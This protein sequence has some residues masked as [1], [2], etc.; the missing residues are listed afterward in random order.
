MVAA[1]IIV[2]ATSAGSSGPHPRSAGSRHAI[3]RSLPPYWM[4]RPG[5]TYAQISDKTGLTIDQLEAFNPNTDQFSLAP[6]QRLNLCEH[7]PAYAPTS[8]I[9]S[10]GVKRSSMP[11]C[12]RRSARITRVAS[13]IAATAAL[14]SAPR[15]VPAA[16]RTMPSSTT[17]SIAAGRRHGVEVRAEKERLSRGGRLDPGVEV[18]HRRADL[19]PA[20]VLVDLEAA[21]PQIPDHEIRDGTLLAGR[22]RQ[23]GELREQ[24][25]DV[26]RHRVSILC[27]RPIGPGC[28][29]SSY[30]L[31][32][33]AR[34]AE[35]CVMQMT[36]VSEPL[37]QASLLGEAVEHGP[38][39]VFVADENGRYVA[40]NQAACALVGYSRE[41]LLSMRVADVADDA[42][43]WEEMR[44]TGHVTGYQHPRLQGRLADRVQVHRRRDDRRRHAGLRLGRYGLSDFDAGA[45]ARAL[46][47]GV[48]ELA[49][50]RR[51]PRGP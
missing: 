27:D 6:G 19:R 44:Q 10:I 33:P 1:I 38:A 31:R 3:I 50:Q 9:S 2:V 5:D 37:I 32:K 26:R 18:A 4:V 49:E 48:D 22:A 11:A 34:T 36:G 46:E 39:A 13:S 45:R 8:P 21:V 16:F 12:G 30:L 35:V 47:R 20:A 51:R 24:V 7:P 43:K 42:G 29:R 28:R 15:I 40:V 14:S 17:G 41:E 25:E 23:R